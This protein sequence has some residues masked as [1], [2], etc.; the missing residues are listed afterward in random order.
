[1]SKFSKKSLAILLT[2]AFVL[3]TVVLPASA[4]TT[5][6]TLT[7]PRVGDGEGRKLGTISIEIDSTVGTEHEAWVELPKDFKVNRVQVAKAVYKV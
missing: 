7:E 1:M 6:S 3:T 2:I 4:K 5:Y